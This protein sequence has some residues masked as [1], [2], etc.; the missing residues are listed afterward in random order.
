MTAVSKVI[1][2]AMG[3]NITDDS[4]IYLCHNL[5]PELQTPVAYLTSALWTFF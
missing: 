3:L 2:S 5:S 1:Y 4:D